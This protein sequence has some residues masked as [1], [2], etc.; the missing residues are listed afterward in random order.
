MKKILALFFLILCATSAW[1]KEFSYLSRSPRGLLLGDAYTT[2]ADDEYTLFYNPAILGRHGG[3]SFAPVDPDFGI[4]NVLDKKEQ[5]RF[6]DFPKKAA[7]ISDRVM[8]F[9]LYAHAGYT[10]GFKFGPVGFTYFLNNTHRHILRNATYPILDLNYRY[11]K[12]FILGF[13][14]AWGKKPTRVEKKK[15]G[16]AGNTTSIGVSVKHIKRASLQASYDLF[17]TSLLNTISNT[18]N[19]TFQDYVN[20]LGYATGD[21]WGGDIGFE[22]VRQ[23]GASEFITGISVM[24]V[25]GTDFRRTSGKAKVPKQDMSVN[26]GVAF[27]QN[28][29]LFDYSISADV[30]PI[31]WPVSFLSKTHLGVQMG[32]PLLRVIGGLNGGYA[33]YGLC[34]KLWP[35]QIEA[36]FY[37]VELGSNY[38][39]EE[40]KRFV[41]YVSLFDFSFDV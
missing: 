19:K 3:M 18:N 16:G 1:P 17:G 4:T 40:G 14:Y 10:P 15:N 25:A 32:L 39:E 36:G 11:D 22:H 41:L 12:G 9:P 31:N 37:G 29:T 38:R 35:I 24:D 20:A 21:A 5:D 23:W 2:L 26:A 30:H 8:G 6:K 7:E 33:S 28:Y 34:V 13:A 27:K